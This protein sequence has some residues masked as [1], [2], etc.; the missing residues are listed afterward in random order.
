MAHGTIG[1]AGGWRG[2]VAVLAG[3]AVLAAGLMGCESAN[4]NKQKEQAKRQWNQARAA[5]LGGVAKEQ[6]TNGNLPE[7]RKMLGQALKLD[8]ENAGLLVLSAKLA[9]EQGQLDMAEQELAR[10]RAADPKY[11]EAFY[12]SGVVY[13]RWQKT[14]R[15]YE[16]YTQA[17]E[18]A[19]SELAYVLAQAEML[20]AL[21]RQGEALALLE[22]K[23][24][25]FEHSGAIR[26]EVGQLLVQQ[27]RYAEAAEVLRQ[28][29]I[30]SNNDPTVNEHLGL[31]LYFAKQYKD[32]A[33]VLGRLLKDEP[34]SKR[35]DLFLAIGE[36]QLQAGK[37]RDARASFE[38]AAELDGSM[39][40]VWL[41]LGKAAMELGDLKRAEL[42]LKKAMAM[43]PASAPSNLML[44]YLRLKQGR[45]QDALAAFRKAN[46][47]DPGDTV[48]VCMVGYA[49]EKLG[50]GE[51][52]AQY[53]GK[54]LRMK[55]NDD[56]ASK[57]MAGVDL[58]D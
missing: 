17:A 5:V 45:T 47:L 6:Y 31:A 37:P 29:S 51:Q 1:Q 15:A 38:T 21:N 36:C 9:I 13:Q 24:V 55:P 19:P 8:P 57:L 44:G 56:F 27:G 39:P 25:Y 7:A 30:L 20:V 46:E 2:R 23:V 10:A 11:G 14:D 22:P 16:F 26:D 42:S 53:Y 18:K 49:L 43:D 52:A 58:H 50:K 28:A 12:L 33:E 32:A 41:S 48:S 54:A 3:I 34:Y 35:A 4:E 40:S